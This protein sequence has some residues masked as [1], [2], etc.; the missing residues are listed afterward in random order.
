[1]LHLDNN[2]LDQVEIIP[3]T[4]DHVPTPQARVLE[5]MDQVQKKENNLTL[6]SILTL[7]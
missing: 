2:F 5:L 4:N 6:I 1:M 3:R 7:L